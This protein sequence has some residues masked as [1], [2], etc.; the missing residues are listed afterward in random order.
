MQKEEINLG[1]ITNRL[2]VIIGFL[3]ELAQ[4]KNVA[5]N[6][7]I[8]GRLNEIGLKDTDIAKILCRTRGYVSGEITKYKAE[9]GKKE[10][11]I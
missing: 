10:K 7:E 9:K 11:K 3:V 4:E 5:S 2:D 1:E 8:I 6:R